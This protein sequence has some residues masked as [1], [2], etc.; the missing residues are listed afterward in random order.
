LQDSVI[1]IVEKARK[2]FSTRALGLV[3]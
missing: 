1:D 3:R 2:S